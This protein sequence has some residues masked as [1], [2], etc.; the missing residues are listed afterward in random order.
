MLECVT[1]LCSLWRL[2]LWPLGVGVATVVSIVPKFVTAWNYGI[3]FRKSRHYWELSVRFYIFFAYFVSL[4]LRMYSLFVSYRSFSLNR[5]SLR[6]F[7]MSPLMSP[8]VPCL[9]GVTVHPYTTSSLFCYFSDFCDTYGSFLFRTRPYFPQW[10]LVHQVRVFSHLWC[11]RDS[12]VERD[13]TV[14]PW[15][16]ILFTHHFVFLFGQWPQRANVL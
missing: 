9:S 11:S 4:F 16:F 2:I 3:M 7:R 6:S 14:L 1:I 5:S 13:I 8:L 10:A 15:H 12:L